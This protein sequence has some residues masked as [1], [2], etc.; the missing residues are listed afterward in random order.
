LHEINAGAGQAA[1]R[2][3]MF[4]PDDVDIL[5]APRKLG[6]TTEMLQEQK[7]MLAVKKYDDYI[8]EKQKLL[9]AIRSHVVETYVKTKRQFDGIGFDEKESEK[10]AK[11]VALQFKALQMEVFN[12]IYPKS[13]EKVKNV[14]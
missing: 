7:A 13:G 3:S 5:K 4:K 11:H 6:L 9:N 10:R 1:V 12:Q 2:V 14:Y 8:D